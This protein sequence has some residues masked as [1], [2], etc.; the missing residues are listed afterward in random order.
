MLRGTLQ[1]GM[2]VALV[3]QN[4]LIQKEVNKEL[5]LFEGLGKEKVKTR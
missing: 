2:T 4:G 5:Y 3:K 1:A